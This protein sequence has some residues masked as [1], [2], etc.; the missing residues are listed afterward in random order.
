MG[1]PR[2]VGR[3]MGTLALKKEMVKYFDQFDDY[4]AGAF[5]FAPA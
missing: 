3:L 1:L 5:N 2:W 4:L